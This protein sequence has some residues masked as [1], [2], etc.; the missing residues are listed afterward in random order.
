MIIS[1][2]K[3][4][5]NLVAETFHAN[6]I[7]YSENLT[8]DASQ[9]QESLIVIIP[10]TKPSNN[11]EDIG[12]VADKQ[13]I[14]V[15]LNR[16][17]KVCVIIGDLSAWNNVV[18]SLMKRGKHLGSLLLDAREKGQVLEKRR[19][20]TQWTW[21]GQPLILGALAKSH[22]IALDH[23]SP[24]PLLTAPAHPIHYTAIGLEWKTQR[25]SCMR[26]SC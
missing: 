23:Q 5:R 24:V 6:G 11:A 12:F 3:V 9:G 18:C 17:Q 20:M 4:N 1:P 21:M 22:R 26:R 16:A 15:T 7:D 13:Q 14:N 19:K 2:Y 25:W 8:I 10:L